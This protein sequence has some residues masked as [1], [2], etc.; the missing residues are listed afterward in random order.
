LFPLQGAPARDDLVLERTVPLATRCRVRPLKAPEP[1]IVPAPDP[2][3]SDEVML[4]RSRLS[5]I[6][7]LRK[8]LI[9]PSA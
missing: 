5:R 6:F 3:L 1:V 7:F 9:I 4:V 8:F 2:E